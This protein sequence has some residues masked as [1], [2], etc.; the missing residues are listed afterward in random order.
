MTRPSTQDPRPRPTA[1]PAAD[2][3]L[4]PSTSQRKRDAQALQALGG[5]LVA[6]CPPPS[7]PGWI[8]RSPSSRPCERRSGGA[9]SPL[10]HST[11]PA[12]LSRCAGSLHAPLPQAPSGAISSRVRPAVSGNHRATSSAPSSARLA[13]TGIAT[14]WDATTP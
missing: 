11:P 14:Q 4:T 6:P 3:P 2:A 12:P 1:L 10:R 7:G 13:R 5:E 8:C 9:P